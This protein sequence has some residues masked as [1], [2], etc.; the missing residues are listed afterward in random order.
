M[1][2]MIVT[3]SVGSERK[4]SN[5]YMRVLRSGASVAP[6]LRFVLGLWSQAADPNAAVLPRLCRS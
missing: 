6:K 3:S 2:V 5:T 4:A 1:R